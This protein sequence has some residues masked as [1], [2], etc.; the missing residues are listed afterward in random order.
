[1]ESKKESKLNF[2]N[3]LS[4]KLLGHSKIY[5][6]KFINGRFNVDVETTLVFVDV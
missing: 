4:E 3:L 5:W 1:M 6:L 2:I